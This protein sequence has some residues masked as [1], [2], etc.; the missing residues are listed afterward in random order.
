[1]RKVANDVV[2]PPSEMT[3]LNMIMLK[4][5]SRS[6]NTQVHTYKP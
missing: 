2:T 6:K 4:D 1:M 5:S 3:V